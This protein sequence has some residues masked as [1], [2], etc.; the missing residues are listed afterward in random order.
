MFGFGKKKPVGQ[1][2]IQAYNVNVITRA[3]NAALDGFRSQV[4]RMLGHS[5]DGKRNTNEVF[6]YPENICY[7]DY[8]SMYQRSG[9]ATAVV[10]KLPGACW[11]GTPELQVGENP[12]L[13][14]EMNSLNN[15]G[16][17]LALEKADI[18]N[19]IGSFSVLF[20]GVNDGQNLDQPIVE[21]GS[22]DLNDVYFRV[23]GYNSIE[24]V[25]W[26]REP[27]S[28]RLGL[29]LVYS[30]T[31][32][33]TGQ[34][35][36]FTETHRVH[37]SRCVHLAEGAL[38]SQIEGRSALEDVYNIIL[39]L[40]KIRGA[41]AEAAFRNSRQQ[42]ALT[43]KDTPE[44]YA[45]EDGPGAKEALSRN[46]DEF[47]NGWGTALKLDGFDAQILQ[48]QLASPKDSNDVGI[49]H[50]VVSTG[51][52]ARAYGLPGANTNGIEDRAA[53]NSKIHDR[54]T[55][56]CHQWLVDA[57]RIFE[58][59]GFFE[60]PENFIVEW[61]DIPAMTELEKTEANKNKATSFREISTGLT[62]LGASGVKPTSA[63]ECAG[64]DVEIDESDFNDN[65]D[66]IE[67]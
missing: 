41:S 31:I 8:W 46:A 44:G 3:V 65:D 35:D 52:P 11:H 53:F 43:K 20:I 23:Y 12:V 45:V 59:A 1:S 29:P 61:P 10:E 26:D 62:A 21:V 18:L 30:L 13:S 51:V 6:G 24:I 56:N 64:L 48:P 55:S 25:E 16:L 7:Y 33:S 28:R 22:K 17:F 39:D 66:E 37:Y 14:D 38:E 32:T 4:G 54:R 2:P 57:L 60:L 9:I 42:L 27:T 63:F 19:R 49:Q 5:H 47:M 34:K 15:A 67:E 36:A 58:A 50:L 40:G